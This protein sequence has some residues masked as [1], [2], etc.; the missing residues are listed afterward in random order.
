MKQRAYPP[1]TWDVE[2]DAHRVLPRWTVARRREQVPA[3]TADQ[4][5]DI[6]IQ[7]AHRAAGVPHWRPCIRESLRHARVL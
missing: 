4:A 5:L 1:R 7:A 6:V 3:E 2:I